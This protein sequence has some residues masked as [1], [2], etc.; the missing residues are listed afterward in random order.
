MKD[1][2]I[3]LHSN[4]L[5]LIDRSTGI[6]AAARQI[7]RQGTSTAAKTVHRTRLGKRL[8]AGQC[9]R[10]QRKQNALCEEQRTA[11]DDVENE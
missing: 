1:W 2:T 3:G 8:R 9:G 4:S 11:V 7:A 10:Q 6:A 5:L